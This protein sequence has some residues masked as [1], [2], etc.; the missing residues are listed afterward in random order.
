MLMKPENAFA[1]M[2]SEMCKNNLKLSKKMAKVHIKNFNKNNQDTLDSVMLALRSY[3]LID[4]EHKKTRFDWIFGMPQVNSAKYANRKYVEYGI[5]NINMISDDSYDFKT[6]LF[7]EETSD[8]PLLKQILYC[9]EKTDTICCRLVLEV[10]HLA[11]ADD[12]LCRYIYAIDPPTY[13]HARYTD[14]FYQ[15][16]VEQRAHV[17]KMMSNHASVHSFY[18]K[19]L[20][21]IDALFAKFKEFNEKCKVLEKEQRAVMEAEKGGYLGVDES[22]KAYT[23]H[24]CIPHWPPR[25]LIGKQRAEPKEIYAEEHELVT[26][27]FLEVENDWMYSNPTG[28]F[29][30]SLPNKQIK[31]SQYG[32]QTTTWLQ[33]KQKSGE[34]AKE[35]SQH[36]VKWDEKK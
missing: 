2:L 8:Y 4:D 15:Y 27:R 22:F 17:E 36:A 14:W 19:R 20:E 21:I 9:Q 30:I 35:Y 10:I 7:G 34:E 33:E 12:D 18:E 13:Q 23:Y 32:F 1:G 28:R 26:V 16:A 31:T 29:N 25:I 24:E 3:M 11:C 6:C 5:Q